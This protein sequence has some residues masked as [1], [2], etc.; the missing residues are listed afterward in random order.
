VTNAG[1]PPWRQRR[2]AEPPAARFLPRMCAPRTIPGVQ[3]QVWSVSDLQWAGAKRD[4]PESVLLIRLIAT[5]SIVLTLPFSGLVSAASVRPCETTRLTSAVAQQGTDCCGMQHKPCGSTSK[6]CLGMT[7]SLGQLPAAD[8][9]PIRLPVLELTHVRV[10]A[11]VATLLSA[12]GPDGQWRPP[13][14]V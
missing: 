3:F 10:G 8:H 7:C 5:L 11:P 4:T 13:R 2:P 14:T 1:T 9:A 6:D 12:T